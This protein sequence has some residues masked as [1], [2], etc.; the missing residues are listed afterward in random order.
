MQYYLHV[1][2]LRLKVSRINVRTLVIA[3]Y[4]QLSAL[5]LISYVSINHDLC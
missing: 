4:L 1:P 2:V 3:G 5:P